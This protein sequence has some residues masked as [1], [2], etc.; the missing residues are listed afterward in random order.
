MQCQGLA[1]KKRYAFL[2][3][4]AGLYELVVY[5]RAQIKLGSYAEH[6]TGHS[7]KANPTIV[8]LVGIHIAVLEA[9]TPIIRRECIYIKPV[10]KSVLILGKHVVTLYT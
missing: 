8:R 1:G 5:H 10:V 9:D 6:E 2:F 3:H 4:L 7:V